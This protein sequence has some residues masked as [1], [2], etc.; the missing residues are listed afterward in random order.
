VPEV[1]DLGQKVHEGRLAQRILVVT[2]VPLASCFDAQA[3]ADNIWVARDK[4]LPTLDHEIDEEKIE[5]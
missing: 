2:V 1:T 3:T 4:V 5:E